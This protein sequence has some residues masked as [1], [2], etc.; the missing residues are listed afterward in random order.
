MNRLR[1]ALLTIATIIVAGTAGSAWAAESVSQL[2]KEGE[3]VVTTARQAETA[4]NNVKQSNE[5]LVT[6][7]AQLKNEQDTLKVAVT[8][9]QDRQDKVNGLMNAYKTNCAGKTLPEDKYKVCK[10]QE[11]TILAAASSVNAAQVPL[12]K[13]QD[14]FNAR[15]TMFQVKLKQLKADAPQ[16]AANYEIALNNEQNWLNRA[17]NF[18]LTPA[19]RRLADKAR[20]ADFRTTPK[21][22]DALN[23]MS[24]AALVCLKRIKSG[25]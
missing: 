1:Y 20:C 25:G 14:E 21:G 4:Q 19:V 10:D 7:S 22:I 6:E 5:Q 12:V 11:T 8:A 13:R 24:A 3:S 17:R 9:F 2:I 15:V 23:Q 16:V 18:L